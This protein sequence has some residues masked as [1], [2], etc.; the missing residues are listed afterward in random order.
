MQEV[1]NRILSIVQEFNSGRPVSYPVIDR[2]VMQTHPE[3][4]KQGLL[5]ALLDELVRDKFLDQINSSTY[6]AC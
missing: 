5:P 6:R 2:K 4:V 3:I 1:K